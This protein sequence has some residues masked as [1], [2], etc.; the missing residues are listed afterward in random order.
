MYTG[1]SNIEVQKLQLE[2]GTNELQ[3]PRYRF[4]KLLLRQFKSI[5]ILI[6]LLAAGVT[7]FLGQAFDA[8]FILVFVALGVGLSLFQEYKSNAVSNK[9]QSYLVRTITVR[10]NDRDEE[11]VVSELV[12]GDIIKVE[13]GDIVPADAKV[14]HAQG[15]QVDETTFTGESLPVVK[16][17]YEEG[18]SEE[19]SRLLQGTIVV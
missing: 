9:L 13:P 19:V 1:L 17:A 14:L 15:F 8:V 18:G 6:L 7:Y 11:V 10:R 5:F 2:H 16:V 3:K 12:P 4:L